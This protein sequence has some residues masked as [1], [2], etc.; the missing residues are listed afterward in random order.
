M[1]DGPVERKYDYLYSRVEYPMEHGYRM[2]PTKL[3]PWIF[4]TILEDHDTKQLFVHSRIHVNKVVHMDMSYSSKFS[5]KQI[6][7]DLSSK[8]SKRFL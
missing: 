1:V 7:I 5:D 3:P 2:E 6:I 8:I 4:V